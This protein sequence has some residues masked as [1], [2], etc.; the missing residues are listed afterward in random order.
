[1]TDAEFREAATD[2][3]PPAE[4]G[5]IGRYYELTKPGIAGYVT[6]TA[7]VAYY[8]ATHGR[9]DF[10]PMIHM[11]VGV[12]VAT[13]G[14]LAM[15]QYVE[16]DV[17]GRMDRTRTRPLPSGR[18]AP[19]E[20]LLVSWLLMLVGLAY[21]GILVGILPAVLTA[22]S[23]AA[24]ILAYTPLKSHSY[25]ATL[26]GAVPGAFP[27]LIGWSAAT[28]TLS[29]GAISLFLIAFLWQLPHVLALAWLLKEDYARV[30]FFLAPK[31]D[32]N[33]ARLAQ[34]MVFHSIS[35][36]VVSPLP[37]LLGYT[38]RLY[39]GGAL[40]L[41]VITLVL[42]AGG[43]RGMTRAF[44]RRVFLWSILYQPLFLALLLI[45]TVRL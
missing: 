39:A 43:V 6:I 44:A 14:A 33:G 23:A 35:L 29:A 38:G 16:R 40:L 28:G 8:V 17:D 2:D 13:A 25:L 41:G 4:G 1:M 15:N 31:S 27:A 30:G 34:H 32:E 42:C 5:R 26:V 18:M 19:R 37:T 7:G 9:V 10:L 12:A 11:L 20:A 45:D 21:L 22:A 24:Y 36:I 3:Q